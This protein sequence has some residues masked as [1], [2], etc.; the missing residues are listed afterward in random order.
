[1]HAVSRIVF[2][3]VCVAAAGDNG[4]DSHPHTVFLTC[5][6]ATY[7]P[8]VKASFGSKTVKSTGFEGLATA[9]V[10]AFSALEAA[11]AAVATAWFAFAV[12]E[13]AS[14]QKQLFQS[15]RFSDV[16]N[17]QCPLSCILILRT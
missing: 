1:M 14:H 7:K 6:W 16:F 15:I 13:A 9:A 4:C 12:S 2:P 8:N 17:Q 11:T 3:K 10:G 5:V